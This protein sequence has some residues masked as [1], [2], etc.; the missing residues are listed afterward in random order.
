MY[1]FLSRLDINKLRR[2]INKRKASSLKKDDPKEH[3]DQAEGENSLRDDYDIDNINYYD[4]NFIV[5]FQEEEN[6]AHVMQNTKEQMKSLRE[7]HEEGCFANT[8]EQ[9][10]EFLQKHKKIDLWGK[11]EQEQKF[12]LNS[13]NSVNE[14]RT[15]DRETDLAINRF[16]K[17]DDYRKLIKPNS[18]Q[19]N[20]AHCSFVFKFVDN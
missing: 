12:L 7:L 18:E 2:N 14:R 16:V 15:F 5:N 10:K 17:K 13:K 20:H 8:K 1:Y 3:D 11:N 4:S 19:E 9:Y 6:Y